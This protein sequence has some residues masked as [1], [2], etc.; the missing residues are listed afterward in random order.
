MARSSVAAQPVSRLLRHGTLHVADRLQHIGP[1]PRRPL[2][3]HPTDDVGDEQRLRRGPV[4]GGFVDA[5]VEE[6]DR[7]A[8]VGGFGPPP[9]RQIDGTVA[10]TCRTVCR[11]MLHGSSAARSHRDG[12]AA[13]ALAEVVELVGQR[14]VDVGGPLRE[15]VEELVGDAGDLGLT[16]DDRAPVDTETVGELG[17]QDRLVEAAEHPLV[18]L[19]VAG[20][21]RQPATVR[22]LHLGGD[23]GVGVDLWIVGPRRRLA[24]RRHRQPVRVRDAAGRRSSGSGSS[25]RTAPGAPSAALTA[26]SCASR[27]RRSPVSAH[28]TD[29]D[30]GAENV[31]SNPDTA[32]T[33]PPPFVGAVD[34]LACRAALPSPGHDPTAAPRAARR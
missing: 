23:D 24:E 16:V 27:S 21:E 34:E 26:T 25:T 6:V 11:P 7:P 9:C 32:R 13:F 30:F 14:L 8:G 19:Q 3:R 12:F 20:V 15:H 28:H 5:G 29:S 33:T 1:G 18:P 22:R 2:I 31:A 10:R 17:A 4:G